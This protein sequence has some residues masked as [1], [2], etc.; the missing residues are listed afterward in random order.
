MMKYL[1][2][3]RGINVGGNAIIK[4]A[5]LKIF[6]EGEGY[7]NVKTYIQSGNVMLESKK[8]KAKLAEDLE[9]SL[10]KKFDLDLK[11]VV[12]THEHL[13]H[14]VEDAPKWWD[15]DDTSRHYLIFIREP[16]TATEALKECPEPRENVDSIS[17]GDGVIYHSA[18]IKAI[19]KSTLTK[20]IGT[21]IYKHMTIRNSNTVGKL[22]KLME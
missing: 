14:I 3:L 2:L 16:V 8:S 13:K 1:V 11:V 6:L 21:P 17:A 22:L 10:S 18:V 19:T 15:K 7:Q 5:D 4:M 20:V 9:K 12:I